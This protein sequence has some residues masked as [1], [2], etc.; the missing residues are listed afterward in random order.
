MNRKLLEYRPDIEA[1]TGPAMSL[2]RAMSSAADERRHAAELLERI[3]DGELEAYLVEL[4]DRAGAPPDRSVRRALASTLG[5]AARRVFRYGSTTPAAVASRI[6]GLELEGLSQEDQTFEIARHF[7][8][9][10][11]DAAHRAGRIERTGS[12]VPDAR[13]ALTSAARVLAPG[14]LPAS[15]GKDRSTGVWFRRANELVVVN[16]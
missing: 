4:I 16:P 15:A 8:R 2:G 6:F 9:F 5:H 12:P 13:R 14:L 11:S 10:A 1:L 7:V 3:D